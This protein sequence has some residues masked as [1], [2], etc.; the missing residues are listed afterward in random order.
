M[1]TDALKKAAIELERAFSEISEPPK[2]LIDVQESL[3][4]YLNAAKREM[5]ESPVNENTI[6]G[7]FQQREGLL[8]DYPNYEEQYVN[9]KVELRGGYTQEELDIL[10]MMKTL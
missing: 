2:H 3:A 1:N 4:P 5:I 10:K 8:S 7:R 6:P 9:F